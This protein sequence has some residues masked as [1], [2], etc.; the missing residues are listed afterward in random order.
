MK[1]EVKNRWTGKVQFVADIE[2]DDNATLS[3]KIGLSVKWA[4]SNRANMRE[5]D[6]SGA[7]LRGANLYGANLSEAD[8]SGANLSEADMSGANLREADLS[9]ANLY[10]ADLYGANLSG[11]NL[12]GA[13]LSGANLYGA[14]LYGADLRE[15]D[16]SGANLSEADMSGANLR[17]AD[18]SGANLYG[19]DLREADLYGADLYGAN[20]SGAENIPALTLAQTL[21]T[22]EGDI[23]G[24]KKC[25]NDVIVKLLIPAEAKRH[26]ATGRKCRAQFADVLEVIGSDVGVSWHDGKTEYRVGQRVTCDN[27]GEDRF[28]EC[29]GGIHFF[30]TRAEAEDY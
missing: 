5:T 2:C 3:V 7:N 4:V 6:L 30:I 24:W 16:L 17:E 25:K 27:W 12:Y 11:A 15:A 18:L 23:I 28:D 10:G 22:P 8:M 20:L 21:I 26:N 14:N 13:N 19:A 29:S 1:F 9:G